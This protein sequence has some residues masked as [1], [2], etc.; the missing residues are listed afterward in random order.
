MQMIWV[1]G[2]GDNFENPKIKSV[3]RNI[4]NYERRVNGENYG[5]NNKKTQTILYARIVGGACGTDTLDS[6][7]SNLT[8]VDVSGFQTNQVTNMYGM[9]CE[10]LVM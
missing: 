3:R 10:Y 6:V 8:E 5:K 4:N 1:I 2:G 7:C 9:F